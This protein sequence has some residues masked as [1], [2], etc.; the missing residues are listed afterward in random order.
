MLSVTLMHCFLL[1]STLDL[2][3]APVVWKRLVSEWVLSVSDAFEVQCPL[4]GRFASAAS[5]VCRDVD[6][7]G[8]KPVLLSYTL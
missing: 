7:F 3:S 5:V 6:V 8:T 1:K 4:S 2:N